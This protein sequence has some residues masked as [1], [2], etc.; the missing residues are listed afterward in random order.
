MSTVRVPKKI[1]T[2]IRVEAKV[3]FAN[4]RTWVAWLN[5]SI[6][7]GTLSIA[8]FNAAKD[9]VALKFAYFYALVSVG[10]TVYAGLLYQRRITMI[11]RRYPGSFD[12]LA[13]P[14]IISILLFIGILFNFLIRVRQL[15]EKNLPIPGENLVSSLQTVLRFALPVST[16]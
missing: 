4:E 12:A 14:V 5:L 7:M 15:R 10:T 16:S 6:L 2:P 13:G 11:R 3:W 9:D 1:A 8:L